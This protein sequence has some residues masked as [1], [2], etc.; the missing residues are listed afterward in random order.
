[1]RNEVKLDFVKMQTDGY[2]QELLKIERLNLDH[3]MKNFQIK[4]E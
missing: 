3:F 4:Q 2:D 1:M